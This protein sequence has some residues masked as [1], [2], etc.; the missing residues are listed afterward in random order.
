MSSAR[1]SQ[2]T[3]S[4]VLGAQQAASLQAR[5]ALARVVVFLLVRNSV[6]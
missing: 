3:V 5:L 2:L 4:P 1:K 6:G